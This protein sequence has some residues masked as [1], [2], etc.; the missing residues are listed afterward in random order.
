M[1]NNDNMVILMANLIVE[2]ASNSSADFEEALMLFD[3][4][5]QLGPQ[6]YDPQKL[7][8]LV[9]R[10]SGAFIDN[11][12][13]SFTRVDLIDAIVYTSKVEFSTDF[14]LGLDED[15]FRDLIYMLAEQKRAV[16]KEEYYDETELDALLE[17]LA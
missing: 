16:Y 2:M 14:Y 4:K 13:A 1:D 10:I 17:E 9:R 7:L 11:D 3:F 12:D 5:R 8:P 15:T 6:G